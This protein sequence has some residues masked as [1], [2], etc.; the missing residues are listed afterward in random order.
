M[1]YATVE[2][3]DILAI[4]CVHASYSKARWGKPK[5]AV[6][7]K[8]IIHTKDGR[9]VPN[10][11]IIENF[12]RSF[13]ITKEA[14]RT[15][16]DKR[17]YEEIQHLNL[18]KCTQHELQDRVARAQG[19]PGKKGR[20][21]QLARDPYL[22][23]VDIKTPVLV[24]RA[25]RDKF[26]LAPTPASVAVYDIETNMNSPE[27]EIIMASMTMKERV[28]TRIT[29]DW[30]PVEMRETFVADVKKRC[31]ELIGDVM[32]ARGITED[33]LDIQFAQA[34]A[35]CVVEC[36]EA[37]HM[38]QPDYVNIFNMKFDI[39]KSLEALDH[40]GIN[41][42]SVFS[43]PR[44][45][46]EF[47]N[48]KW[49]L[50]PDKKVKKNDG[51]DTVVPIGPIDQWHT[52]DTQASFIIADSMLLY[53]RIRVAS[54]NDP[55]YSLDYL[56]N[57]H[58][59]KGKL[60]FV[61]ADEYEGRAWHE[62][63]QANYPIEYTVYNI[64]DCL[65][66]ESLDEATGDIRYTLPALLKS[67]EYYN[68]D[69]QP[70]MVADD[71]HFFLLKHKKMLA[72]TSDKMITDVDGFSPGLR[73]WINTLHA[74]LGP[75]PDSDVVKDIPGHSIPIYTHTSD[76]D[77]VSTYPTLQG[78]LNI[79]ANTTQTELSS[80]DGYDRDT[81][82]QVGIDLSG[83]VNNGAAIAQTILGLPDLDTVRREYR[84]MFG[85]VENIVKEEVT[86]E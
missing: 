65:A 19:Q 83:G 66:T 58:G 37:A 67:S 54:A 39:P 79:E 14:H 55:S 6:I 30:V 41:Y 20:L 2:P 29:L 35:G 40:A 56:L 18:F 85:T 5:D 26:K 36:F 47:R 7:V 82:R 3:Q 31:R 86:E 16:K 64:Y 69:S 68:Y 59:L 15:H 51:E 84:I 17:P 33:N 63:M 61:E 80:V 73:G 22:Y 60:K 34:P 4:E 81:Y 24:K 78:V 38:W 52:C 32:D 71:Y 76:V 10:L 49:N 70:T 75:E 28:R 74:Y 43:D 21:R 53:K 44:V 9:R 8:E 11:R 12:E 25:Y 48:F 77:V 62:F 23:G 46:K 57:K 72:S 45:P 1:P 13:G 50:G 27:E 42:D